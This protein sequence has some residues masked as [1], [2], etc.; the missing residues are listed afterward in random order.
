MPHKPQ[1][2]RLSSK[3]FFNIGPLQQDVQSLFSTS[4]LVGLFFNTGL[5]AD[6]LNEALLKAYNK[7]PKLNAEREN[8]SVSE[9]NIN[10][11]KSDYLPSITLSGS[12]SKEDTDKLTNQSGGDASVTDVDPFTTSLLIEQT[13]YDGKSRNADLEKNKLGLD[14]SKI[15][16]LK[17]EQDI[18]YQ[19]VEAY[20]G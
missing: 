7:N 20:T 14:I 15:K 19:A 5:F 2:K 4:S 11:S 9:E 17:V 1:T 16:L 12:K 18:L 13:L 8:I 3:S 10:I 6:S